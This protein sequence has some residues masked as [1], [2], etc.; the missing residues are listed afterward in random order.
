MDAAS[1]AGS[2]QTRLLVPSKEET[3]KEASL[4]RRDLLM[5]LIGISEDGSVSGVVNGITRLQKFL[6]L[7]EKEG[8]IVP[9]GD[10]FEFSPY[11]AGPYSKKLYDDL[12]LL[13]NL[14]LVTSCTSAES[15]LP[16][17]VDISGLSFDDLI[18]E[19][20]VGPQRVTGMKSDSFE[21]RRFGLTSKGKARLEAVMAAQGLTVIADKIR[22]LKGRFSHYSLTDLLR[23]VYSKYP[24][25]TTE[26]EII[27]KV[28]GKRNK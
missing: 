5:A 24:E 17:T 7:L 28:M 27:D 21:E 12:E 6:F 19:D 10:G 11:K 13:E 4:N 26:S 25:M 2:D 20:D 23:H 9:S 16:E 3:M 15:T 18:L 8:G 22:V 1:V 14:D